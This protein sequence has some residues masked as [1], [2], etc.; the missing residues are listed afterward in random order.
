[1]EDSEQK[2]S[3]NEE[4]NQEIKN[5]NVQTKKCPFCAEEIMVEAVLCKYCKKEQPK[6]PEKQAV[7]N[8]LPKKIGSAKKKL[9]I[10]IAI[11]VLILL[12]IIYGQ[13]NIA[14]TIGIIQPAPGSVIQGTKVTIEGVV[15][16]AKSSVSIN[17]VDVQVGKDGRFFYDFNL[18]LPT[19]IADIIAK[20]GQGTETLLFTITRA[21]IGD[22]IKEQEKL[23]AQ[24]E[25]KARIAAEAAKKAAADQAAKDAAAQKIWDNSEAGKICAANKDKNWSKEDCQNLADG[26]IWIGMT[27]DMLVYRRGKP[28]SANPSNY[29]DGVQWQWCWFDRTPS[30]FYGHDD[31]IIYSYN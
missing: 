8:N 2:I 18:P 27:Y 13:I 20:H 3:S 14:P 28:D 31:G 1:M 19:N 10:W 9:F 4:N 11:V 25:E 23:K 6:I 5:I 30:C 17:S 24:A 15:S 26:K 7:L 22:E 21:L 29:G 16:P 12:A